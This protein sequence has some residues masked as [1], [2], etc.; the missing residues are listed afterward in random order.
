MSACISALWLSL[1]DNICNQDCPVS[2]NQT[3]WDIWE[4]K[5]ATVGYPFWIFLTHVEVKF[6]TVL[7]L[8]A[9]LKCSTKTNCSERTLQYQNT[10]ITMFFPNVADLFEWFNEQSRWETSICKINE[11]DW[12]EVAICMQSCEMSQIQHIYLCQNIGRLG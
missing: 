7:N 2:E 4:N 8:G 1:M 12:S 3:T 5:L 6:N 11:G 10:K 9:L